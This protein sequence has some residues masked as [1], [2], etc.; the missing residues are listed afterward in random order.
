MVVGQEAA[1][2][3][4]SVVD[5]MEVHNLQEKPVEDLAVVYNP[6]RYLV[7]P[8]MVDDQPD[9]YATKVVHSE[10]DT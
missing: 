2:N 7:D 9:N 4:L 1:H 6:Q 8:T 10:V 5:Q 3:H